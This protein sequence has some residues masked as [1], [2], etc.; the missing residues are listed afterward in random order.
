MKK[1]RIGII[2]ILGKSA[3][4]RPYSRFVRASNMSI[5]PQVVAVWCE[6]LGHDVR[7]A[8][9]N[10][11][12]I[13]AGDPVE[14]ADIVM[15]STFTQSS[16]LA[17]GLSQ[18]FRAKGAITLVGGPHARAYP[19]H[20]RQYFDYVVGL[21]DKSIIKT[22][23]E[24]CSLHR[25]R[26]RVLSAERHPTSL[27]R[28]RKRWKFMAPILKCATIMKIVPIVG[29][30]GCPY[31]CSFCSDANVPYQ[32]LDFEDLK[33]DLTYLSEQRMPRTIAC[34]H[35]PNFG[36]RF[37]DYMGLIEETVPPGRLK[38]LAE[39]SLSNLSEKNCIRLAQNGFKAVLSGIESWFDM[40]KKSS[41]TSLS[42]EAKVRH[43][44]EQSNMIS[45]YIPYFQGNFICFL[46]AD[47]GAESVELT[48][49]F[50]D[51]APGVI[52][53]F[54]LLNVF[55]ASA[56]ANQQLHQEGRLL[57]VPFHFLNSLHATNVRPK[58][59]GWDEYFENVCNVFAHAYSARALA[60]RFRAMKTIPAA[61]EAAFRG[62]FSDRKHK[63]IGN[64]M[65]MRQRIQQPEVRRY[66]E[67]ETTQL[68]EFYLEPIQRDLEWL[69]EWLPKSAIVHDPAAVFKSTPL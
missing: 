67:G 41:T 50:I 17:Y 37:D 46:D 27:A 7:L 14:D 16:M 40:G 20:A 13:M 66:F 21:T 2:D 25:P 38:F 36:V 31:N 45:S 47:E 57:N 23:L 64:H 42:G 54:S 69:W 59:T 55:G 52:P 43:I 62:F 26:G 60:R 18:Y 53:A 58:N 65:K 34:W 4:R 30:L 11:P 44:A 28:L 29:S 63:L 32:P 49:K 6:E 22:V 15:I 61:A 19:E 3:S 33:D 24:D 35:D 12:R 51:L 1:L 68:P 48:K 10:G 39:P 8:Y 5:M 56:P 9:Y